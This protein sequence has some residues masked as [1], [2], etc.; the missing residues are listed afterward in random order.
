M[1]GE[2]VLVNVDGGVERLAHHRSSECGYWVQPRATVS[3]DG[4]YI[5]FATDWG[6]QNGSNSCGSSALGA[7]DLFVIDRDPS[8]APLAVTNQQEGVTLQTDD[9]VG[10]RPIAAGLLGFLL[11]LVL[12]AIRQ[13]R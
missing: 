2:L 7:G 11:I 3:Q 6:A 12:L 5:A 1:D 8:A 9:A 4:R 10:F 13:L